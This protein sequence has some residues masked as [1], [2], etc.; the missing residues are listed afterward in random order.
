MC[1]NLVTGEGEKRQYLLSALFV[2]CVERC[3]ALITFECDQMLSITL[4]LQMKCRLK[5]S[6]E[7]QSKNGKDYVPP[8]TLHLVNA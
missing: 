5:E 2:P 4:I 6:Q 7:T 3:Y 8:H 1:R